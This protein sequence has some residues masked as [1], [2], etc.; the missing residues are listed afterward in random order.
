MVKRQ[1]QVARCSYGLM[2]EEYRVILKIGG[3]TSLHIMNLNCVALVQHEWSLVP[4][5]ICGLWTNEQSRSVRETPIF[6][7]FG[8]S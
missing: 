2:E 7:S 1:M 3:E 8:Y 4:F 5:I 6:L